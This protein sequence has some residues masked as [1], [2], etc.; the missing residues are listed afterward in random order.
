MGIQIK[1]LPEG[2][3]KGKQRNLEIEFPSL[4]WIPVTPRGP[5]QHSFKRWSQRKQIVHWSNL[6]AASRRQNSRQLL[7]PRSYLRGSS[8]HRDTR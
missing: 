5:A 6:H 7:P 1:D 3:R 4:R 8:L 2:Q